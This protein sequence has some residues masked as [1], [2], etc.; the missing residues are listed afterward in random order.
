[1][2]GSLWLVVCP[3]CDSSWETQA[4]ALRDRCFI[5]ALCLRCRSVVTAEGD[6][7]RWS[8]TECSTALDPLP[9]A[10]LEPGRELPHNIV[11]VCCPTCSS[12]GLEAD[13]VGFWD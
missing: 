5:P 13:E 6:E 8:C 1:M 3:T 7:G 11:D 2:P 10:E 12:A 4:G 9:G